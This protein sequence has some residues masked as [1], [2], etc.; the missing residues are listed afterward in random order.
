[1]MEFLRQTE[2]IQWIDGEYKT[3]TENS[4]DDEYTYLFIDYLPP[5][6]FQLI[7]RIWRILP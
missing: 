7:L 5:V 2:V 6:N 1:M 3:I 4:V